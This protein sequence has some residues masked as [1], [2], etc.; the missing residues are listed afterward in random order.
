M[1]RKLIVH[2]G[3]TKTGTTAIQ[4]YLS[5]HRLDLLQYGVFYPT[6]INHNYLVKKILNFSPASA[7]E[8]TIASPK[9]KSGKF[10]LP[11]MAL[12]ELS[13]ND[14]LFRPHVPRLRNIFRKS[15]PEVVILSAE[16]FA[17][18]QPDRVVDAIERCFGEFFDEIHYILYVRPHIGFMKAKFSEHLKN[19]W[20]SCEAEDFIKKEVQL[21]I[22]KIDLVKSWL[23]VSAK[24]TVRPFIRSLWHNENLIDDFRKVAGL[25]FLPDWQEAVANESLSLR[26]LATIKVFQDLSKIENIW[27]RRSIGWEIQ[28]ILNEQASGQKAFAFSRSEA[29]LIAQHVRKDAEAVDEALSLSGAGFVSDLENTVARSP[30][31]AEKLA[32]QEMDPDV[33]AALM[34]IVEDFV[35]A[36]G[37]DWNEYFDAKYI[38]QIN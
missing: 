5:A 14:K 17:V 34:R 36:K 37:F 38:S 15:E 20:I 9:G 22:Q 30:E 10:E 8:E 33:M 6:N 28:K 25:D 12:A 18:R 26:A 21:P 1:T 3:Q 13:S 11:E 2:V 24:C 27:I 35:T 31:I 23:S 4:S 32:D 7:T 16:L 29:E 19:G